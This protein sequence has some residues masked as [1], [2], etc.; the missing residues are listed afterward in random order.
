VADHIRLLPGSIFTINGTNGLGEKIDK[1]Y[2]VVGILQTGGAEEAFI[3]MSFPDFE[4][5]MAESGK[6]D[7]VECSVSATGDAMRIIAEEISANLPGVEARLVKRVTESEGTVLTKLQALIYLVTVIV[8]LLIM[9]CVATTMMAV[10]TERRKEIGL[11]KALGASNESLMIEFMGE[12]MFL[13][14]AGGILGAIFGFIFAQ[15]VSVHVFSRSVSFRPLFVLI[16]LG[17]SVI[18]TCLA[19]LLPVHSATGVDPAIVLRDE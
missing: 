17:V 13:G 9:I 4:D 2:S 15:E 18:I 16:T 7:V 8:L 1:K 11:K 12:G 19:C 14:A 5:M 10:V 3:F 6:I